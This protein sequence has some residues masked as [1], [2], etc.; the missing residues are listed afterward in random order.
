MMDDFVGEVDGLS[1]L[2]NSV[3]VGLSLK[4]TD[5]DLVL[6]WNDWKPETSSSR[7]KPLWR[8]RSGVPS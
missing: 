2:G 5:N 7:I 3:I 4:L 1:K 8:G 6:D